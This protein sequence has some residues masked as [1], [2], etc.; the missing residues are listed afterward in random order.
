MM[1]VNRMGGS[2]AAPDDGQGRFGPGA[3]AD[4]TQFDLTQRDNL[5]R[6]VG[7]AADKAPLTAARD[8]LMESQITDVTGEFSGPILPHPHED[9]A[10]DIVDDDIGEQKPLNPNAFFDA[11]ENAFRRQNT[12]HI[13]G[14]IAIRN[15]Q[16]A[17]NTVADRGIPLVTNTNGAGRRTERAI[18]DGDVLTGSVTPQ[19]FEIALN[20]NAVIAGNNM[21]IRY[22]NM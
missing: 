11:V 21:T 7:E 13:N 1:G 3:R 15:D 18:G 17:E 19:Q 10:I 2:A 12:D 5:Y 22:A 6:P 9:G 4:Q 14:N 8:D 16:I 20:G